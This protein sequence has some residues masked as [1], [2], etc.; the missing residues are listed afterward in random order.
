MPLS[1]ID[2]RHQE[3]SGSMF[4]F[5]K[6]EVRAFLEQIAG[7]IEEHQR[8]QE[9][10]IQ[11]REQMQ[12]EVKQ[13]AVQASSA[14]EDLRRREEL[15]S[16]TLVFAEKT[17]A[18]IIANARKEAENIIHEAELKAKRAIQEAKQYLGALEHQYIHIKEQKRQFLMQFKSELQTFMERISKDP[19]LTKE[20]ENLLDTEFRQIKDE[21]NP[22]IEQHRDTQNTQK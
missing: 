16:R 21:I 1:P 6:K 9:K 13:E 18:D 10:D 17:K 2:I 19:L 14:V 20:S 5:S 8:R 12:Y 7:E 15:I 11:R 22:K 3:F 4:G